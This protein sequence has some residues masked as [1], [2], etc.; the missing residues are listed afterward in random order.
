MVGERESIEVADAAIDWN[1]K[2]DTTIIAP[3]DIWRVI[4]GLK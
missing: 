3:T 2:I 4:S 1:F